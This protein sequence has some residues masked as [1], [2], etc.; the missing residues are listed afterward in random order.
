MARNSVKL[1]VIKAAEWMDKI[2]LLR[3]SLV[4]FVYTMATVLLIQLFLLPVIFPQWHAGDGLLKGGDW[5]SFH[6]YALNTARRIH[7]MGWTAWELRPQGQAPA[8][9]ASIFYALFLPKAWV[10]A[11]LNSLIHSVSGILL[12]QIMQ[13]AV[14]G[15]MRWHWVG[16]LFIFFPSSFLWT[17][18]LHKDG[19]Q[20]LGVF[21]YLHAWV[22]VF[23]RLDFDADFEQMPFYLMVMIEG[24][25]GAFCVWIVRPYAVQ[26]LQV[27]SILLVG[28]FALHLFKKI[29]NRR[30]SIQ[31][32]GVLLAFSFVCI[33]GLSLFPQ[34]RSVQ[35]N[36]SQEQRAT[37]RNEWNYSKIFPV[38]LD[39]KFRQIGE[40]RYGF[41]TSHPEAGSNL[42]T[43][44]LFH[45]WSDVIFYFPRA[46]YIAMF[47][48][49]PSD[50][51]KN[52]TLQTNTMMRRVSSV[53]MLIAYGS[54][55]FL[56]IGIPVFRNNPSGV[57]VLIFTLGSLIVYGL[58]V[59]NMGTLYRMRF[60]FLQVLIALGFVSGLQRLSFVSRVVSQ[61]T[62]SL[63]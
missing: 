60:G 55:L 38:S 23:S 17:A 46:L 33:S 4:F 12:I 21:L 3:L 20:T 25:M 7:E 51:F 1:K 8:G 43:D 19:Y 47:S 30:W 26:I 53:E 41:V 29:L 49:F 11:P 28:W 39:Q 9:I 31:R 27:I 2:S 63:L 40:L 52:G 6:T 5:L 32:A 22:R 42:D 61:D 56:L 34:G 50:W 10:L 62:E 16:F 44:V 36:V 45:Q 57:A 15:R 54:F 13:A 37:T 18:S 48:P 35:E 14:P 24:Y 59:C 58:V